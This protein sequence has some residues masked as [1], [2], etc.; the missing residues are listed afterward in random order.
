M[1]YGDIK[2]Q[3]YMAVSSNLYIDNIS[4]IGGGYGASL[5]LLGTN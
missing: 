2:F 3:N 5:Y 1:E 4:N